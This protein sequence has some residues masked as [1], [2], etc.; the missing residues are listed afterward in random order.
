MVRENDVCVRCVVGCVQ[1]LEL[2]ESVGGAC[3][4]AVCNCAGGGG[5]GVQPPPA[6]L[7][8]VYISPPGDSRAGHSC[9]DKTSKY[10]TVAS[11]QSSYVSELAAT[12]P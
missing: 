3:L 11:T 2:A 6:I 7:Y 4:V 8:T 5:G 1:I 10:C 12:L 9:Q